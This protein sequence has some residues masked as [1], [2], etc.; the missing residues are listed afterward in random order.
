MLIG[1]YGI[2]VGDRIQIGAVVG[3]VV[4]LGLVRMHLMELNQQGPLGPTGRVV[5]FPNLVVFQASGG[6]FKQVPAGDTSWRETTLTLPVVADYAALKDKLLA[7][8]RCGRRAVWGCQ[9]A[10][11]AGA[12]APGQRPHGGACSVTRCMWA[13]RAE[14]DERVAQAVLKVI[15]EAS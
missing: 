6:L 2:R 4:D 14:V 1:K 10:R 12:N 11:A 9:P 13:R 3:E 15:A 8:I 7:A 5:A